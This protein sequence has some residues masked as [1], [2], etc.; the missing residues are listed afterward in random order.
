[1]EIR[2][3]G[4]GDAEAWW[5]LRLEALQVEPLA[6]GKSVEEHKATPVETFALRFR[7]APASN[8]HLGAFE[9][10]KLIG[11]ATFLRETGV[12][13]RHKG[14][15]YGV[16]VTA[17]Q[18]GRGIGRALLTHL[19]GAARRDPSLEQILLAVA[20]TQEA[21][22]KLYRSFGFEIFGTEPGALKVGQTYADEN[23]M[24]LRF[25]N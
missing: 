5:Q 6:F 3:L 8:L 15:I 10:G 14:R 16:Y 11:M 22:I 17:G 7:D 12:K 1:M 24:V 13:H 23:Y 19:I 2:T 25:Q 20:A 4:E 18:R 21:A 9:G